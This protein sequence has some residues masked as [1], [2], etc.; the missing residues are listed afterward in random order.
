MGWSLAATRSVF[1]YRAVVT[2]AGREE[3]AGGLA[4]LAAGQPAAGLL[5]GPAGGAGPVGF[6]FAGQGAQRAGMAAGLHAASPVFAAAFDAA[7]GLLE[8]E[9]GVPVAEVALGTGPDGNADARADQTLFAQPGLFA[10]QA[11][12]LAVLGACGIR[13]DAVAGHSVGEAAA[14]YAAGVLSLPDA[15]R[16]VAARARLMQDLPPGGAMCAVAASEA[17]VS[18]ALAGTAG[19]SIAA[20]NGPAAVVISG[21]E[22]AVAAAAE[23]FRARGT[24]TRALR[25]SHAFHSARMDPVLGALDQAA[26]ALPHAAPAIWWAG[27]LDGTLVTSPDPAYWAAAARRPVR[28]ADAVAALTARGIR[29]FIEIGPDATLSAL[30]PETPAPPNKTTPDGAAPHRNSLNR[31]LPDGASPD[32]TSPDGASPAGAGRGFCGRGAAVHPGAAAGY[33]GGAGAAGCPGAGARRGR[34]RGLGPGAARGAGRRAAD[35]RVPASAVLGCSGVA[36]RG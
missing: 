30:G 26:A 34:E 3:L 28:F 11:G 22:Q 23:T 14:A 2:G 21:D 5:S 4:A 32:E 31:A 13:P 15:C 17:E 19:V 9:L 25:V 10:L 27:A 8:T 6:V 35:V 36:W 12:L 20:V 18:A 33:P 16:L 24:R 29:T 7:A 1:E